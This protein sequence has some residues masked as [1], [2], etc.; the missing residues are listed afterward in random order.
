MKVGF[1]C[2]GRQ[3]CLEFGAA[4]AQGV[5]MHGHTCEI[6]PV[7]KAHGDPYTV[8][9]GAIMPD[10]D[11]A[12]IYAVLHRVAFRTMQAAK[13]PIVYI[14][15]AY[16]RDWNYRRVSLY[17]HQPSLYLG[18]MTCPDDRRKMFGWE[19]KPW[20]EKGEHVLLAW[21][22]KRDHD[23][24]GWPSPEKHVV[25][26]I[27]ELRKHTKR[28]LLFRCKPNYN[29]GMVLSPHAIRISTGTL[30]EDLANCH[31]LVTPGTSVSLTALLEGIPAII[32]D[33]A[34]TRNISDS[35]LCSIEY[36]YKA[37]E[38]ERIALLNHLAYH[39][40]HVDEYVNG[41]AWA[42]LNQMTRGFE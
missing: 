29:V 20:R 11:V 16:N 27:E 26:V 37:E 17:R 9:D 23:W 3:R 32:L 10:V 34:V 28:P 18:G 15:K 1:F 40:W 39:Q 7:L 6:R 2:S 19:P 14:D 22:D 38:A 30:E 42:W 4:F 24:R 31:A 25:P 12:V 8:R 21:S 5:A 36:P 35:C 33:D 41:D 13:I